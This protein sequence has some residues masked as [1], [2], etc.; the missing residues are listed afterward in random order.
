MMMRKPAVAGQFYPGTKHTLL[1]QLE[2]CFL[3]HRGPGKLP[4][5]SQGNTPIKGYVVPHAGYI[6]SGPI[7]AHAYAHLARN[8]FADTFIILVRIIQG[9]ALVFHS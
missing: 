8:R 1:Q 4:T 9:W 5:L 2:A 6:Y 7:A 3:D